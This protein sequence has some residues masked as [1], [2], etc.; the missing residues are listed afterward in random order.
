[1]H[2]IY[3]EIYR[4]LKPQG[5]FVSISFGLPDKRLPHLQHPDF[6]WEVRVEKTLK[7]RQVTADTE[8]EAEI[9]EPEYH[10]LYICQKRDEEPP[11]VVVE[12]PN[13]PEEEEKKG[14]NT[15]S[16]KK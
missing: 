11:V 5:V 3:Q 9:P 4:V 7:L 13:P 8:N 14:K 1:M 2:K 6:N 15:A 12:D 16:K 10:Y